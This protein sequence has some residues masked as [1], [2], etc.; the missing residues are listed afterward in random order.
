MTV[1]SSIET[2]LFNRV[3]TLTLSPAL[4]LA[5]PNKEFPG[6]NASGVAISMPASYIRVEQFDNQNE[7]LFL[8]G[9]DPHWRRGF[10]QLTVVTPRDKGSP[11]AKAIAGTVAEHFPAG[12]AL[13]SGGVKVNIT[14]AP[15]VL[16]PLLGD[17]SWDVPV[18][19][20]Y[21]AFA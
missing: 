8:K 10:L 6:H 3:R 2:A 18:T 17:N 14:K 21:E 7:R 12:L 9:S 4:T 15:D 11:P 16:F 13:Y 1:E 20:Y 19:I 5:W